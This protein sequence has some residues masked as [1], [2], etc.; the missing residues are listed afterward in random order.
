[1]CCNLQNFIGA[2]GTNGEARD[3]FNTY[4]EQDGLAGLFMES[5]GVDREAPQWG[6]LALSTP[7]Q[8]SI[9]HRTAWAD[10]TWGDSL[11]D[12]WDDF[13][14]DGAVEE[15]ERDISAQLALS[16]SHDLG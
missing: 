5:R 10:V 15:R 2:D 7:Q 4:R 13:N 11:L 3:N 14:E 16:Q 8:D 9:S 1:M 12:F 6:T